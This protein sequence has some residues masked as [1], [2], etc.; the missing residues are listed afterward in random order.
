MQFELISRNRTFNGWH[1]R[2]R[3]YSNACQCDMTFAI[4]LPQQSENSA[5]PAVYW[6][7]GLTCTDENFMQKAGARHKAS[8]LGLILIAPDTSPRG[9]EV[10]NDP[11][12]DLG[13]GAGFYLN[14]TREPWKKHYQ[15]YD[16]IVEELPEII[17]DNFPVNGK[18]SISGHSMGGH[19][20]LTIGLKNPGRYKSISAFSPIVNPTQCPWGRKAF[21]HY[22]GNNESVWADHDACLLLSKTEDKKLLP[23]VIDQGEDDEF[24]KEQLLL[25]NFDRLAAE[26]GDKIKIQRHAGY[27]HSYF[28]IETLIDQHLEFHASHLK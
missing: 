22:L 12:Y 20:A 4:Y 6:L 2:Y 24:L 7:S 13:Q 19:G 8:E 9:E 25:D 27:D 11:A 21:T 15:M 1:C 10:A 16:Y 26:R 18:Q 28:F 3:H 23:I 5:M 14:A 17:R